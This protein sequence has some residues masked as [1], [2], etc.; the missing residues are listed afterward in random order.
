M[1]RTRAWGGW[2]SSHRLRLLRG[3]LA[4][5]LLRVARS[6]GDDGPWGVHDRPSGKV[7]SS[8]C[9]VQKQVASIQCRQQGTSCVDAKWTMD[10]PQVNSNASLG[11]APANAIEMLAA[12]ES[13]KPSGR[14]PG[15]KLHPKSPCFTVLGGRAALPSPD[16]AGQPT[17]A[18]Q[19]N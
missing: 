18:L 11:L 8:G 19:S 16:F 5:C 17:T 1:E 9:P 6:S 15:S 10:S 4:D 13:K 14:C 2:Q 12:T 3:G 7:A